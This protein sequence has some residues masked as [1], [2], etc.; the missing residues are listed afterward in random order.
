MGLDRPEAVAYDRH[1]VAGAGD[2]TQGRSVSYCVVPADLAD[3]LHETLREHF[4]EDP[5]IQVVVERRREERR[6]A[7]GRREASQALTGESERRRVRSA[8]GRRV[9]DRRA[10]T[11]GA[12]TPPPI[13]RKARRY[14]ERLVFV[15]RLEPAAEPARDADSKRLVIRYQGGEQSAFGELYMRYFNP[16]YT[17]AHVALSDHHEAEDVTQQVFIRAL[18]ALERYEL[19]PG[20]PFRGWLFSIARN[21]VVTA[22]T[23]RHGVIL[24]TPDQ[25]EALREGEADSGPSV[26]EALGWLTDSE[27]AMFVERLP[28]AQRQVLTLRFMLDLTSEEVAQVLGRTHTSVRK[29]QSRALSTLSHRL[30]AIGRTSSRPGPVP[31]R[32]RLKPLTVVVRRKFVLTHS[33]RPPRPV[34]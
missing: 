12:S 30:A 7:V 20:V 4:R 31:V 24:D 22:I 26:N 11:V 17:Y 25:L 13:P 15:E 2:T 1:P 8:S 18:S 19:R 27:V 5:G 32:R 10:M 9:A 21:V 6:S 29:L 16:V 28:L 14:A 34:A 23:K 3:K 33:S